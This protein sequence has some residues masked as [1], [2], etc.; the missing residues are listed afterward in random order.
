MAMS[1]KLLNLLYLQRDITDKFYITKM[2]KLSNTQYNKVLIPNTIHHNHPNNKLNIGFVSG[3]F[4]NHPVSFFI[5]SFLNNFDDSKYRVY[6]YSENNIT[7]GLYSKCK[8]YFTRNKNKERIVKLIQENSIDILIDLSGHTANNRLDIFSEK[9]VRN[10]LTYIGYPFTTGLKFI[11]YKITDYVVDNSYTDDYY[12]EKLLRLN[13]CFLCYNF[14]KYHALEIKNPKNV[15]GKL[16]IGCFNR[17][18]KYSKDFIELC[19]KI[20]NNNKNFIMCFKTKGLLDEYTKEKFLSNF[21]EYEKKQI[22]I[23]PCGTTHIDHLRQYNEIH[24]SLD[25]FPYNGTTTTCESLLMGVPVITIKDK[26][27]NYS[28]QNVSSSILYYSNL[29]KYSKENENEVMSELNNIYKNGVKKEDIRELFLNGNVCDKNDYIQQMDL[30]F[31]KII[32]N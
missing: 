14:E 3:D 29:E 31:K 7:N 4:E 30:L 25:T 13:R 23:I 10:Q 24:V 20:I 26:K 12:T 5:S 22:V 17:I 21:T 11:D 19:K 9:I 28:P 32:S 27:T 18:N 6:L 16:Y 1:N 2:H 15:N 8:I